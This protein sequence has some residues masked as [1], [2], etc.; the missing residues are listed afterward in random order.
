MTGGLFPKN[1]II[2]SS[3]SGKEIMDNVFLTGDVL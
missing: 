2:E 3:P 1:I